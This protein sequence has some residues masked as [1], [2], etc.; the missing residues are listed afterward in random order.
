MFQ[1]QHPGK[2]W[3]NITQAGQPDIIRYRA[4]DLES[5]LP[6]RYETSFTQMTSKEELFNAINQLLSLEQNSVEAMLLK[7]DTR[8]RYHLA[9]S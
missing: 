3:E 2:P 8:L 1:Y 7:P 9:Q 5:S 6:A 4:D